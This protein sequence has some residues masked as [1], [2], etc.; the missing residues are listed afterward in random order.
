MVMLEAA[1]GSVSLLLLVCPC[2]TASPHKSG[3][4]W[5]PWYFPFMPVLI[6]DRHEWGMVYAHMQGSC[7]CTE[8]YRTL[9]MRNLLG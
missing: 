2:I 6:L 9:G 1:L 5:R 4:N 7:C 8:G 3:T